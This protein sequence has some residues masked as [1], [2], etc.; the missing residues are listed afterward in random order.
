MKTKILVIEDDTAISEL[1][2]MN[3][4]AAGYD[5]V[6]I[7]DGEEAET[8]VLAE[9]EK[10]EGVPEYALALLDIMLPGKDGF[11]LME[12]MQTAEIPVI[13]LTAKA[14]VVSKVHGLRAGAEDYIV[15]PFEVLE[16]LVR[17][18][19]VLQRTG[20]GREIIEIQDVRIDRKEHQ[21]TKGGKP[22][23]LKPMEYE[24][25]VLLAGN[26]N[27]AFS[28]EQLLSQVWG[29]DYMG[30]T[31]TV[32]VHIGRLRKKLDFFDVIRTIPKTGYRLED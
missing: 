7:Y 12:V 25:L 32:D 29:S 14:D 9:K 13:Y 4:E 19:K 8:A 27:V 23:A 22:V 18:E 20:R 28:R 31:R 1:I 24:L 6:P 3:L 2:C 21:V 15:K 17:I 30:E 11:Q 10:R 5:P 26:K 16:L